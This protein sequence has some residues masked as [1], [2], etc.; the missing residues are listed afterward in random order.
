MSR[1]TATGA[2]VPLF[3]DCPLVFPLWQQAIKTVGEWLTTPLTDSPQLS[4]IGDRP[5]LPLGVSKA[6][7]ALALAGLIKAVRTIIGRDK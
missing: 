6:E 1:V 7:P 4:L 5:L 2:D 3:W